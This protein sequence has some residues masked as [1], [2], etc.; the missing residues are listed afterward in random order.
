MH[1]LEPT[2]GWGLGLGKPLQE[3]CL[4]ELKWPRGTHT[5]THLCQQVSAPVAPSPRAR[6]A[7]THFGTRIGPLANGH[8]RAVPPGSQAH[9]EPPPRRRLLNNAVSSAGPPRRSHCCSAA[10]PW[11]PSQGRPGDRAA[12]GAGAGKGD[13]DTSTSSSAASSYLGECRN[14]RESS[15]RRAFRQHLTLHTKKRHRVTENPAG[16]D[17]RQQG[18]R[19]LHAGTRRR[20]QIRGCAGCNQ[21]VQVFVRIWFVLCLAKHWEFGSSRVPDTL[22]FLANGKASFKK[23]RVFGKLEKIQKTKNARTQRQLLAHGISEI[24]A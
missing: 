21:V 1:R 18:C 14:T 6:A 12:E 10:R 13:A 16:E 22:V 24:T 23:H 11:A 3:R 7:S 8:F 19:A 15:M 20:V 5:H 17:G 4:L 9:R 2:I